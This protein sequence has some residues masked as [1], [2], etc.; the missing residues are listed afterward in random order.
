MH[1][2]GWSREKAIDYFRENT[3]KSDYEAEVEIDRYLT[4][5]GQSLGYKLG[6]LSSSFAHSADASRAT[7]PVFFRRSVSRDAATLP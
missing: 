5:P 3:G 1:A 7:R 4:W 2:L 6:Q